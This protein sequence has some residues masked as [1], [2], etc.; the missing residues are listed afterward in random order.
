MYEPVTMMRSAVASVLPAGGAG[1]FCAGTPGAGAPAAGAFCATTGAGAPDLLTASCAT[2][3]ETATRSIV[4][5]SA[6]GVWKNANF[7]CPVLIMS[8][9]RFAQRLNEATRGFQDLFL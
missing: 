2:A 4:R 1:A 3:L 5:L 8:L 6:S 9:V 7:G